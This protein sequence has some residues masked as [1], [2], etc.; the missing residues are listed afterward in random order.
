MTNKEEVIIG[1]SVLR[2]VCHVN[3]LIPI[4]PNKDGTRKK[5][6]GT[7]ESLEK[8]LPP[9]N[10]VR[11]VNNELIISTEETF[12]FATNGGNTRASQARTKP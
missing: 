11:F 2:G 10:K 4:P 8:T 7:N 3:E 5:R 1:K 12:S 9:T 6:T